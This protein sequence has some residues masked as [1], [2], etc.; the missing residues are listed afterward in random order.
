MYQINKGIKSLLEQ[1]RCIVEGANQLYDVDRTSVR[2]LRQA[3]GLC[4]KSLPLRIHRRARITYAH[5]W[6][7]STTW[8]K[9]PQTNSST[10]VGISWFGHL[11]LD[12]I[13]SS[14]LLSPFKRKLYLTYVIYCQYVA[15]DAG[16]ELARR[17]K[18]DTTW[19]IATRLGVSFARGLT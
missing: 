10:L 8:Q 18:R 9:T 15:V 1:H 7:G 17:S 3:L 16:I 5:D 12:G 13:L 11:E 6:P 14:E 19:Y 2:A 4:V